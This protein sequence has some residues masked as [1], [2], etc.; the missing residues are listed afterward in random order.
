MRYPSAPFILAVCLLPG[1]L[2]AQFTMTAPVEVPAGSTVVIEYQGQPNRRDFV[3]IVPADQPEGTYQSYQYTRGAKV[4]LRAPEDAG[5]YEIR[6]L[7]AQ[8]PYETLARQA[9]TITPVT[10]SVEAV[11]QVEAGASFTVTWTGPDNTQDFISLA[12]PQRRTR[13]DWLSYVYTKRGNPVTLVAPDEPG[14]YEVRY[15]TGAQYSTLARSPLVVVGAEATLEAV[16]RAEAGQEIDVQWTGPANAQDFVAVTDKGSDLRQYH[17]YRYTREGSPLKLRM[18]DE[19]GTY[20]IRY[21]TGQSYTIL[22]SREVSVTS[23]AA[24]L[25]APGEVEGGTEFAVEWTGPNSRGDWIAIAEPGASERASAKGG[26]ARTRYGSPAT[27]RAPFEPGDYEVRYQMGQ[28]AKI[29]AVRALRVMPPPVLPGQLRV[30]VDPSVVVFAGGDAV[31]IILDAS[32]SMLQPQ[33]GARRIDT[34]REVLAALTGDAIPDGTPFALRVFGHREVDSCR[35]D[36]E[37]PLQPLVAARV[38]A[39]IQQVQAMNLA[40]TPIA[41]SLA[42]VRQDLA[43][44]TGERVVILI[45]DGEETCDGDPATVIDALRASGTD[46]RVNI[47]GFAIDDADLRQQFRYWADLGGGEYHDAASAEDLATSMNRALRA[48]YEVLNE[49]GEIVNEGIVDDAD[50]DLP[51][52]SYRV[53]T[54]GTPSLEGRVEIVSGKRSTVWLKA[55]G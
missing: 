23:V 44:V 35:T 55:A 13:Q 52:G 45:T 5:A 27:L 48:P 12:D 10:A 8:R 37:V 17:D 36:L 26:W 42:M 43:T 40:R 30:V 51:P 32:G 47:V 11:T 29:L 33:D 46:V 24:T 6:H 7:A 25:A 18:P 4:Q 38:D 9:L 49:A 39:Q 16:S 15:Q 1:S 28:S 53:R 31:E 54:R 22:A 20:E 41:D 14:T 19:A 2:W 21:Q 3:T 34:A 50:V